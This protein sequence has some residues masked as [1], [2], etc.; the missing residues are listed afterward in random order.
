[1]AAVER[2][3]KFEAANADAQSFLERERNLRW[4]VFGVSHVTMKI[5]RR[6]EPKSGRASG[7]SVHLQNRSCNYR[8]AA[9]KSPILLKRQ[10][11]KSGCLEQPKSDIAARFEQDLR[12]PTVRLAAKPTGEKDMA[13]EQQK[14]HHFVSLLMAEA[15]RQLR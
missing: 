12:K 7:T 15:V 14:Q 3:G 8:Y 6:H 13:L 1:M 4:V 5:R 9:L 10:T 11:M 2:G